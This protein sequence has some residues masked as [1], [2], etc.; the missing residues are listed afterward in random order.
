MQR[1]SISIIA[2]RT[3]RIKDHQIVVF[4]LLTF[5]IT[6]GLGAC[7]IFFPELFRSLFGELTG[8]HPLY[9][10]AVAAPTIA[11]TML[12]L[13]WEAQAARM[14]AMRPARGPAYRLILLLRLAG[15]VLLA[16]CAQPGRSWTRRTGCP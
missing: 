8:F 16:G 7:V 9:I 6:W 10:L 3:I 5:A 11:A 14:C 1:Y 4:C 12:T 15:I 13:A 2:R